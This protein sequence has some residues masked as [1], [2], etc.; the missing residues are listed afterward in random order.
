MRFNMSKKK[1]HPSTGARSRIE[2]IEALPT[3]PTPLSLDDVQ[4]WPAV[5][6]VEH[7]DGGLTVLALPGTG[8]SDY[9]WMSDGEPLPIPC[10][11]EIV[12]SGTMSGWLY[13]LTVSKAR[14]PPTSACDEEEI[15][16]ALASELLREVA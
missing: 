10:D 2:R 4:E 1:N 13:V 8:S 5:G 15:A 16:Q 12:A 3:E 14:L 9:V 11:Q 7:W 6:R